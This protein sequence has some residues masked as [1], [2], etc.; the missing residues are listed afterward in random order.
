MK[1]RLHCE[2]C[3]QKMKSK[4]SKFKGERRSQFSKLLKTLLII[5][6]FNLD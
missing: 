6:I 5:Y 2:G 3:M 4:I 1:M